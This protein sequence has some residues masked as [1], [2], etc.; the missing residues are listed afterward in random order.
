MMRTHFSS[1]QVVE[2]TMLLVQCSYM[3]SEMITGTLKIK[4]FGQNMG[5]CYVAYQTG[6]LHG[7]GI[8]PGSKNILKFGACSNDMNETEYEIY[9]VFWGRLFFGKEKFVISFDI[10]SRND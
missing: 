10:F 4:Y 7:S 5:Y 3:I 9:R 2:D 6:V 8:G 1:L